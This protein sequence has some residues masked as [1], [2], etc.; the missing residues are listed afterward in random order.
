MDNPSQ[1]IPVLRGLSS[2]YNAGAH[3]D[4]AHEVGQRLLALAQQQHDPACLLEAYR[5]FGTTTLYRGDVAK[6]S[7][8]LGAALAPYASHFQGTQHVPHYAG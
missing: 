7:E 3:T 2:L 6:T 8:H 1:V 5:S 4:M